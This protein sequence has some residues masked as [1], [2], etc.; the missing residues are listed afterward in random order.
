MLHSVLKESVTIEII[1][2]LVDGDEAD[3]NESGGYKAS[4]SDTGG[5]GTG[6]KFRERYRC[7]F[8]HC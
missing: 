4:G 6:E 2:M 5:Y 3:G 1:V 7:A 8:C